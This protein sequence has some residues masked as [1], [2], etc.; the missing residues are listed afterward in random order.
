MQAR[1]TDISNIASQPSKKKSLFERLAEVG[2]LSKREEATAMPV[3]QLEPALAQ[4]A[5]TRTLVRKAEALPPTPADD[6]E[7]EIPAFLRRQA[8]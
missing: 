6:D 7:L 1:Q 4:R 3:Q 8:N 5:D 2:G